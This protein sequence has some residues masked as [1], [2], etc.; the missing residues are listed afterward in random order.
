MKAPELP[1]Q[2]AAYTALNSPGAQAEA[3]LLHEKSPSQRP[4]LQL[5][6]P[7]DPGGRVSYEL[8]YTA[9]LAPLRLVPG[10]GRAPVQPPQDQE[11]DDALRPNR[12]I[13]YKEPFFQAWMAREKLLRE[14]GERDLEFAS[15]VH[16]YI[17]RHFSPGNSGDYGNGCVASNVV[18]AGQSSC[19][20]FSVLFASLMRANRIPARVRFGRW[21]NGQVHVK[22]DFWA[23]GVGW[24]NVET[25]VAVR[26]WR[27]D[28]AAIERTFGNE[29]GIFM[30]FHADTDML[31]PDL[32]GR[33]RN[34]PFMQFGGAWWQ[35]EGVERDWSA[36]EAWRMED[37][38][39]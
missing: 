7:A 36:H 4:Y 15:R 8:T 30:T 31:I 38:G 5:D 17:T 18:R 11:R 21:I 1:C 33:D 13:A 9:T 2:T 25:A 35:G 27:A 34:V 26:D 28:P 19:G 32:D 14:P 6:V 39:P 3:R 23:E 37:L 20:G 22:A 29:E 16:D 24:V 12:T 10:K